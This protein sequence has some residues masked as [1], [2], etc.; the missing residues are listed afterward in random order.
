MD[1]LYILP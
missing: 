1:S